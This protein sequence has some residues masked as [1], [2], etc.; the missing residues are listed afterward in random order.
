MFPFAHP[1]RSDCVSPAADRSLSFSR[2]RFVQKSMK[3]HSRS[4]DI[5]RNLEPDQRAGRVIAVKFVIPLL[6][7]G[8][9][10]VYESQS[11]Q[12]LD[13]LELLV[14]AWSAGLCRTIVDKE[15]I[16]VVTARQFDPLDPENA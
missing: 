7:S 16:P 12:L 13:F 5:P 2:Q 1:L 15:C 10:V 8:L 14:D 6:K 9:R 3:L 4:I 11:T